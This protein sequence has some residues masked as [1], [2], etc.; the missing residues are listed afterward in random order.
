MMK[1]NIRKKFIGAVAIVAAFLVESPQLRHLHKA[2]R[3]LRIQK[4]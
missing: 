1:M 2:M 3:M 4:Q